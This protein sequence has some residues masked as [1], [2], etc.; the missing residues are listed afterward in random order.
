MEKTQ[1]LLSD[2]V[3]N[4]MFPEGNTLDES[5]LLI[6]KCKKISRW[7]I[8]QDRL[9]ILCTHYVYLMSYK[10]VRKKVPIAD[11]KYIVRSTQS[12]EVLLYFH[13]EFD[14]RMITEDRDNFLS[15]LKLRFAHFCP[16]KTLK[17]YGIPKES[18]KEYKSMANK[19]GSNQFTFDNEPPAKFRLKQEEI[20][21]QQE[22][23]EAI[24]E[25]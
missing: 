20:Q 15:L 22:A 8:A 5:P 11:L 6:C 7:G 9:A 2:A 4:E 25:E 19:R 24:Q 12:K 21:S 10:A 3:V 16:Q 17:V 18:L 1:K 23:D 14:I 13:D